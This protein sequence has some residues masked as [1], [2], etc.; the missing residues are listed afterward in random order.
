MFVYCFCRWSRA[1]RLPAHIKQYNKGKFDES[2]KEYE[3]LAEQ[4]TN[5]YRLQYNAGTAAYRAKELKSAVE[6]FTQAMNSPEIISDLKAQQQTFYNLGNTLYEMGVPMSDPEK[7]K[8]TWKQSIENYDHA[9]ALNRNDPDCE[10][11]HGVRQKEVWK[12]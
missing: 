7:Q 10:E 3:R 9:L 5:D 6:H 1:L 2:L 12:S 4:K 11:Q 8:E